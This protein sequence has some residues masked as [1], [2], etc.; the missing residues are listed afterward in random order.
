MDYKY[1]AYADNF[2]STQIKQF[3]LSTPRVKTLVLTAAMLMTG[4]IWLWTHIAHYH[5]V[6]PAQEIL[7]IPLS[8]NLQPTQGATDV[9]AAS[10]I[11]A[12]TAKSTEI[13]D[14]VKLIANAPAKKAIVQTTAP[15]A[16]NTHWETVTIKKG[17]NL[18]AIFKQLKIPT[19]QALEILKLKQA[20]KP[21]TQLRAATELK[22][23]VDANHQI[24][25]LVYPINAIDTLQISKR[26]NAFLAQVTHKKAETQLVYAGST[27]KQSLAKSFQRAKL[28]P[29]LNKQLVAIF[30][31]Q[32]DFS[33]IRAGDRFNILYEESYVGSK[34]VNT[35][36]IVAAELVKDGK[37]H[38]AVRYTDAKGHVEYYT[39]EGL[40]LRKGFIRTPI[41]HARVSSGYTL[42][43]YDPIH[44]RTRAH[45]AIDFAAP[46]GTPIKATGDGKIAFL[47]SKG[48]YGNTIMIK[49]DG[50][51]STLYAH[52]SSYAKG[53][54]PGSSVK[55][56]QV[57]GYVGRSG[58]TTG[59]HLHYEFHINGVRHNPLTVKLPSAAPLNRK[60]KARFIPQARQLIA[61]LEMNRNVRL[62]SNANTHPRGG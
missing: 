21:L 17:H 37:S 60:A 47:G 24:Q 29:Q 8:S 50:K 40:S 42:H 31:D 58:R 16:K 19:K 62:A 20:A 33:K 51:Y 49:H 7:P 45:R 32:I 56:G 35:G 34:K 15:I 23:L 26:N 3:T 39:P 36:K 54:R 53:V 48:A 30:Q 43:R 41:A 4:I 10:I 61:Q 1:I 44:G 2:F 13:N 22:I 38:R 52:L 18:V 9:I 6:A 14:Q 27:I 11:S 55:L 46:T 5:A 12:A 59:A 28:N 57:I 25:Q